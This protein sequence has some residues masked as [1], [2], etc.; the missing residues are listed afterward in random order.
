MRTRVRLAAIAGG[1]DRVRQR[2]RDVRGARRVPERLRL[3]VQPP[4]GL[5]DR[6]LLGLERRVE[7]LDSYD[8][9]PDEGDTDSERYNL[10]FAEGRLVEIQ[11]CEW[12]L[13]QK[14][15]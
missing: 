11:V 12:P 14:E 5:L 13:Q 7:Y 2:Q 1:L 3:R 15:P 10:G 9:G 6:V 4:S 8:S